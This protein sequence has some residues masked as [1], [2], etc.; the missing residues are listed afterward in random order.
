MAVYDFGRRLQAVPGFTPLRGEEEKR[1]WEQERRLLG[2]HYGRSK[3]QVER[4]RGNQ[5]E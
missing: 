4:E 2:A 5:K 3:H 1:D